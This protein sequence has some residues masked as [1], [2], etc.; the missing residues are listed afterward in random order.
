MVISGDLF[1]LK[2]DMLQLDFLLNTNENTEKLNKV[3]NKCLLSPRYIRQEH[4]MSSRCP[5]ILWS[6]PFEPPVCTNMHRHMTEKVVQNWKLFSNFLLMDLHKIQ[7]WSL[8][9]VCL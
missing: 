4:H 1:H 9:R 6:T 8:C 7:S 2:V 5:Y 3:C